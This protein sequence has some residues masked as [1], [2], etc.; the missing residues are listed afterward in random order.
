MIYKLFVTAGSMINTC[1][2]KLTD[3]VSVIF[4]VIEE[5]KTHK[6]SRANV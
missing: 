3:F 4:I 6:E 1:T 5:K 2:R